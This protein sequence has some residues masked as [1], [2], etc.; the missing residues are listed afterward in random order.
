MQPP[1][2]RII[3]AGLAGLSAAVALAGCRAQINLYE[4]ARAAGGRC[5]S[6]DDPQLGMT[7]DNGNHLLL[8]GNHAAR[9]FLRTVGAEDRLTGTSDCSFPFV[10][11]QNGQRWSIRPSRGSFPYWIF[12]SKRRAPDTSVLDHLPLLRLLQE[13]PDCEIATRLRCAGPLYD[14]MLRPVLL[15]ALNTDPASGS[16]TLARNVIRETLARGSDFCRPLTARD[17]LSNAFVDPAI[18]FLDRHNIAF[19]HSALLR[20]IEFDG[21]R[22]TA[23]DFGHTRIPLA[24]RDIII[25]AVPPNVASSLLPGLIVPNSF[26]AIVNAHYRT[27]APPNLPP[28]TGV[29]GGTT[30]WLFAYPQ[31]LSVT[32]SAADVLLD[33]PRE[34]LALRIWR[35]VARVADLPPDIPKWQIV[36]E[37]RATFSATPTQNARRPHVHTAHS[38][39]LLA[40]DWTATGLPATIEGAIR[41]GHTAADAARAILARDIADPE[42]IARSSRPYGVHP[43]STK[44]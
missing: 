34:I 35:E 18:P 26:S 44:P 36:R 21:R 13:C 27:P 40:G 29:I 23:L 14:N 20:R 15:A 11:L 25:L 17:G 12:S 19:S 16:A 5:R 9:H 31:R 41:S 33:E 8:S 6:F 39:V 38:N 28:I 22:A 42:R 43:V 10:N 30:E 24:S 3:G 32:I 7:I 4:A 37:K 1:V 2:I